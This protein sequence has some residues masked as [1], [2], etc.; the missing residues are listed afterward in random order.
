MAKNNFANSFDKFYIPLLQACVIRHT[1]I[2]CHRSAENNSKRNFALMRRQFQI[3]T[4]YNR[5]F[6]NIKIFLF[7]LSFFFSFFYLFLSLFSYWLYFAFSCPSF[8]CFFKTQLKFLSLL[9]ERVC[10]VCFL[11]HWYQT[12]VYQQETINIPSLISTNITF[13]FPFLCYIYSI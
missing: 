1:P 10:A 9:Q 12:E 8:S 6:P 5:Q 13:F 2:S 3:F 4:L 11:E 7:I